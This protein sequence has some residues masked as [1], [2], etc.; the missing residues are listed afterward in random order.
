MSI[1]HSQKYVYQ[2]EPTNQDQNKTSRNDN[3]TAI[4][5]TQ[6]PPNNEQGKRGRS[7]N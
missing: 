2:E 6:K 5:S 1:E 7:E 4:T 3:Q